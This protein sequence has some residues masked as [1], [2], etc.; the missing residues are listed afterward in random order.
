MRPGGLLGHVG[1]THLKPNNKKKRLDPSL[2]L[3][4]CV[5]L[6]ILWFIMPRF[7]AQEPPWVKDFES[8]GLVDRFGNQDARTEI[9]LLTSLDCAVCRETF[10][11]L[12]PVFQE[13]LENGQVRFTV[14]NIMTDEKINHAILDVKHSMSL[15][16]TQLTFDFFQSMVENFD[17]V[18]KNMT[19][20]DLVE[21][22]G[23]IFEVSPT[24]IDWSSK[25]QSSLA[26]MKES[27]LGTVP[28]WFLNNKQIGGDIYTMNHALR[29][30][31]KER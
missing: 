7:F 25:I 30:A 15:V 3:G 23:F 14:V 31:V 13:E 26:T 12:V 5:G 20:Q 24:S 22:T 17:K 18:D 27:G 19:P 11:L 16:D 21:L 10:K 8:L 6:S 1:M 29:Q 2:L 28:G 9:L 4:F